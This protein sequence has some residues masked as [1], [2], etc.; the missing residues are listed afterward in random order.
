MRRA[1]WAG[2]GGPV[3]AASGLVL[4]GSVLIWAGVSGHGGPPWHASG[5]PPRAAGVGAAV[6]AAV[7]WSS[8]PA[9]GRQ[10]P[11]P[12]RP[13]LPALP[14]SPP[15]RVTIPRIAVNA[16]VSGVGLTAAGAIDVPPPTAGQGAF[17]YRYLGAPGDPGPAVIV[18]H[19][20]TARD[21]PAV[22]YRIGELS[23]GDQVIVRQADGVTVRFVVRAVARYPKSAFP[24]AVVYGPTTGPELRLI[25][26]GG[27]FDHARG[28]YRD[29]VVVFATLTS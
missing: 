2:A 15:V 28:S 7:A 25:T 20:D 11:A 22:F 27:S 1:T 4:A 19:V 5:S 12:G 16:P 21:G 6:V 23:R 17:W 18:G 26:C 24:S 9:P 10:A 13:A 14:G 29:N 3:A 8:V